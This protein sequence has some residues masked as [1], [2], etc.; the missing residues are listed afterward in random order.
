MARSKA[1]RRAAMRHAVETWPEH[2]REMEEWYARLKERW[3]QEDERRERRRALF[4][5]FLLLRR[6]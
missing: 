1:E 4:R 3:R 2:R 6:S 5:K